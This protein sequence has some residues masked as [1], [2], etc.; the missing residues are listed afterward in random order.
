MSSRGDVRTVDVERSIY[1]EIA[2]LAKRNGTSIRK[3]V[4]AVLSAHVEGIDYLRNRFSEINQ[5]GSTDTAILMEDKGKNAIATI[6]MKIEDGSM[7][8]SI[9]KKNFCEHIFRSLLLPDW[10]KI[11][12]NLDRMHDEGLTKQETGKKKVAAKV[13]NSDV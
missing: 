4:N 8:C 3:Y 13:V 2:T 12:K 1:E 5:V 6:T 7:F 10:I 11:M 9:C